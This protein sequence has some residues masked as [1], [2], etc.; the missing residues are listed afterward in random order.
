LLSQALQLPLGERAKLAA[1]LIASIDGEPDADAEAAWAKEIARRAS[2]AISGKSNG[3]AWR[4]V[5]NRLK[6][7]RGK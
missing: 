4:G 6:S 3:R 1:D 7:E 2:R 5:L